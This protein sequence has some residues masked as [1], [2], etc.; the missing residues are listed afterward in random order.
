MIQTYK[1]GKDISLMIWGSIWIGG[2]SDLI[3]MQRDSS[4]DQGGYSAAS[5]LDVLEEALPHC[6]EPGRKF[7]QDNARIHTAKKVKEWLLEMGIEMIEWPPY[8]PDMNLIEH[9]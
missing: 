2:H 9:V 1:K 5:Y 3:I 7:M 8:S 4:S 6:Y